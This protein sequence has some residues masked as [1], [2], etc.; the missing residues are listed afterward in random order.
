MAKSTPRVAITNLKI[1]SQTP[2]NTSHILLL[3]AYGLVTFLTPPLKALDSGAPKFLALALLNLA[4]FIFLFTRKDFKTSPQWYYAFFRN[5]IGISYFGMMVVS[6]LSF[7]KAINVLESLLHFAKIFTTFSAAY[8]ISVLI[9]AD[10]RNVLYLSIV[11]TV[12][13][14]Y[15]SITVFS[16]INKYINGSISSI[17]DIISVYSNKN[18]FS[19]SVFVKIPFALWLMVFNRKWLRSLG[20]LG[21]F[22]AILATLFMS[23]RAFY[24]GLFGLTILLIIFFI[25]RFILLHDK[26]YLRLIGIYLILFLSAFLIFS[27]TQ[28]YLYPKTQHSSGKSVGDRLA[29]INA[30]DTSAAAR[31]EMWKRSWHVFK[32]EPILGVGLGN[33]KIV[34]LKEENLTKKNFTYSFKAHNDFIEIATETGIFGGL[35]FISLFL[36]TG[37][38]F[39][40]AVTKKTTP[41]WIALLFL[42]VFGLFCY[43]FD[44]FFNFPQDRPEIQAFFAIYTGGIVAFTSLSS[45]GSAKNS[46][47]IPAEHASV[48]KLCRELLHIKA[49]S[50]VEGKSGKSFYRNAFIFSRC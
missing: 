42:P 21:T 37:W 11:L 10:K 19:S 39:I 5:S 6:L 34:T 9:T 41:E 7:F 20:I 31:L 43:S 29:E 13:L 2:L 26:Y 48:L 15:D 8:L 12:L 47:G 17:S 44:A 33:W 40:R 3:I 1:Q 49:I 36:L 14:I 23:S 46:I 22:M 24:M 30:S 32:Q 35:F 18:I 28:R 25:I 45:Q 50:N 16:G 38:A 4:T 27:T